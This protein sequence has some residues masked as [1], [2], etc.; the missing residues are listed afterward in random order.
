MPMIWT[1]PECLLDH[2]GVHIYCTY[3]DGDFQSGTRTYW[4][5]TSQCE[6][7][8]FEFDVRDLPTY[9]PEKN[10]SEAIIAAINQGLLKL[11]EDVELE[12]PS[13]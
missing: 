3:K 11:P 2:R 7:E 8:E 9:A 12:L 13:F 10:I 5:T 1:E 4:F 6:E